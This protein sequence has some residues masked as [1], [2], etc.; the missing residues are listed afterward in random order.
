M[1][2]VIIYIIGRSAS[3]PKRNM[4]EAEMMEQNTFKEKCS[5]IYSK[6]L[7][8][9]FKV[10]C[11]KEHPSHQL[12]HTLSI[13]LIHFLSK[14]QQPNS[15]DIVVLLSILVEMLSQ[16][17]DISQFATRCLAELVKWNIKQQVE[18][19][20][21]FPVI[22]M[23][24]RNLWSLTASKNVKGGSMSLIIEILKIIHKEDILMTRYI[25][26]FCSLVLTISR[27]NK[28]LEPNLLYLTEKLVLSM[29]PYIKT[30]MIEHPSARTGRFSSITTL[31]EWLYEC[32]IFSNFSQQRTIS[33]IMWEKILTSYSTLLGLEVKEFL[34]Q[35][36]CKDTKTLFQ[37]ME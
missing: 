29:K 32:G 27:N 15:P 31:L 11:N 7:P 35:R 10:S 24:I 19:T 12:M 16:S 30:L 3:D 9:V 23:V 20:K 17:K 4:S 36:A 18:G 21:K 1:H 25:L 33:Y 5:R 34:Y 14:T 37:R 2:A 22:K 6:I 8:T 28:P 13:Q 26:E